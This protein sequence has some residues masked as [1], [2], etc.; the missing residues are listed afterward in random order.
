MEYYI[1][2]LVT[3]H[4]FDK[5][6]NQ[7]VLSQLKSPKNHQFFTLFVVLS[8]MDFEISIFV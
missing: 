5:L 3:I 4:Y 7:L 6:A 8:F 2:T 1:Y